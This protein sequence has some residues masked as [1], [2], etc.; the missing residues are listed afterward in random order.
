MIEVLFRKL[1]HIEMCLA[2]HHTVEHPA[3]R[4]YLIEFSFER[5]RD[6]FLTMDRA[7]KM[8]STRDALFNRGDL[9]LLSISNDRDFTGV[10]AWM[11]ADSKV[12]K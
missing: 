4:M 5:A 9:S 10:D 1:E 8:K 3:T 12:P 2:V 7:M 11:S 6:V